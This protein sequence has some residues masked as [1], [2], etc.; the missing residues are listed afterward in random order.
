VC[1]ASIIAIWHV[2]ITVHEVAAHHAGKLKQYWMRAAR[3]KATKNRG[4]SEEEAREKV[5]KRRI[6]IV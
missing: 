2:S 3:K 6:E 1:P 5:R 4:R